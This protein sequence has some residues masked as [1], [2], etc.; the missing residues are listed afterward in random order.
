MGDGDKFIYRGV[1]KDRQGKERKT[2]EKRLEGELICGSKSVGTGVK[3][4][5]RKGK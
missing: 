1:E 4:S 2:N 5:K 3:K